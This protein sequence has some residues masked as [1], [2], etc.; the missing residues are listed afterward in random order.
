VKVEQV[1]EISFTDISPMLCWDS[2]RDR[3]NEEIKKQQ[4]IRKPG[5]PDLLPPD[6]VNGIEMFGFLSPQIIQVYFYEILNC[7][8]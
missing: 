7:V 6:S 3:V 1:P 8:N 4:S 5:V 2:V